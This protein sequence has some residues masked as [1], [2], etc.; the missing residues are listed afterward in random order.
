MNAFRNIRGEKD[1]STRNATRSPV[2]DPSGRV[3]TLR[4]NVAFAARFALIRTR[5]LPFTARWRPVQN[6][7]AWNPMAPDTG[8]LRFDEYEAST[9]LNRYFPGGIRRPEP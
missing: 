5:R 9:S 8:A 6:S 7:P 4:R 2:N 1:V 3:M